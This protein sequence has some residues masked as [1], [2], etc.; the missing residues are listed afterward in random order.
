MMREYTPMI[1]QYLE[2][3]QQLQDAIVFYR[4]GDFYEMFFEDAKKASQELD[5]VLTG[6]DGGVEERIPMCGIPY[7]AANGYIQRLINKGYKVAIVEQMENPATAKGIVKR[8]VVK[9]HTPGTYVDDTDEKN[10]NYLAA[11]AVDLL[12]IAVTL[13]DMASGEMCYVELHKNGLELEQFLLSMNVKEIVVFSSLDEAIRKRLDQMPQLSISIC[14]EEAA[15]F[16]YSYLLFGISSTLVCSSCYR[17]LHYL[18]ATA[19]QSL[20]HLTPLVELDGANELRM[21]YYTKRNLELASTIR[22]NQKQGTLWHFLDQCRSAMGSRVLRKWIEHPLTHKDRIN[23]RLDGVEYLMDHVLI[24]DEIQQHMNEV[25]D[26]ERL[27]AKLAYRNTNARE[28]LRLKHTLTHA[29]Q[30]LTLMAQCESH[31]SFASIDSCQAVLAKIGHAFVE[32]P[33]LS[34]KEGGMFA[35]G[36]HNKLDE[37]KAVGR[38]GKNMIA[39]LENEEREKTGIKSL[40]VGYHRVF[41]YYIEVS[42]ANLNLVKDDFGYTRKQTLTNCERFVTPQ[43]KEY[44]DAIL[45]AQER[46]VALEYEL[47]QALLDNLQPYLGDLQRL[48]GALASIDVMQSLAQIS[49]DYGYVRPVFSGKNLIIEEGRHPIL[50]QYLKDHRFVANDCMLKEANPLMLITGPN[51]GGKSTYMRQVGLIVIMA[52]MGCFVSAKSCTMPLFD[53]IFTRIGANDDLMS[54]QS[55]F[56]V[57]MMEANHALTNATRNSLILFDEIGRGTSTYDGMALAQSMI[58]YIATQI[59]AKTLFSTHYHELT[60]LADVYEQV[61]NMHVMVHEQNDMVTFLYKVREG[62]ADRSYGI[63]VARLAKLPES[64]LLRAQQILETLEVKQPELLKDYE[65]PVFQIENKE[66]TALRDALALL[67]PMNMSPMQ[68]LQALIQLKAMSKEDA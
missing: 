31:A 58:E 62:R 16:E 5:L 24:R 66:E 39:Q 61:T 26:L 19:R 37:L 51:M 68:A 67:D 52:Q 46:I 56:M 3:K 53:Q 28:M 8:E 10:C 49:S 40:K 57:E 7:H 4:L 38:S 65:M 11:I 22:M 18:Q 47:F 48:A 42:N 43:L 64:V 54:G 36:Y 1:R 33:P 21:D 25:Y 41:G 15:L 23:Q 63:N 34:I 17:M 2:V 32:D 29:P 30:I 9:I 60:A 50:E 44:E 12:S 45:N 6:R 35:D 59:Q 13:A 14:D 55:T 20:A 27:V